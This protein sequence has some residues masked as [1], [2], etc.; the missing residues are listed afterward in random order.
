MRS[1]RLGRR[2]DAVICLFSSI[3]YMRSPEELRAAVGCMAAH[4]GEGGVLVVDGWIRPDAW[5]EPGTVHAEA[6][7]ADGVAVARVSRSRREGKTSHLEMPHLVATQ[8]GIEHLVD[9][10]QLTLFA[11]EEY[12]DAFRSAGLSVERVEGP[13]PGR[14]RYVGTR[15]AGEG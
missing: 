13:M 11:E 9:H 4:L 15:A 7:R 3:G 2:F 1:F 6:G 10:H 14:D 8:E 5:I 12:E